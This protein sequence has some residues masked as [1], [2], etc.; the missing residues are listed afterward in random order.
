[1]EFKVAKTTAPKGKPDW[2]NLG[3]GSYYTDHMLIIDHT[4][5]KGWHDGRIIP[6][7][8]LCLD[9]AAMVLHYALE[10]FEGLKAYFT[11]NGEILVFRPDANGKRLNSSARR[12]CMPE[13]PVEIFVEAIHKIV[14]VDKDWVPKLSGSSLYIRP[15]MIADEAHIGVRRSNHH[16]FIIIL[17]PVGAYYP[18]GLNPIKIYVEEEYVR[19]VSGGT[20]VTKCGGNY[21]ASIIAQYKAKD[22]G[23]TQVLWLDGVERKYIEEVGTMNV[24]FRIDDKI[25]T[26]AL[27]GSILAGI[28]RDSVIQLLQKM[29]ITVEERQISAEEII[30]AAENGRL[31]EAF[32]TGT[33]AVISPIGELFVGGKKQII[34]N[35]QIGPLSQKLY[36]T[37]TGIQWGTVKDE[38]GW[39]VPVK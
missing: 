23:Y 6:Y 29:G 18:E 17:S 19:A 39:T 21:A 3:F 26:P 7:A 35:N 27:N 1:M 37:L 33:A 32:G 14:S 12:L 15:F 24:M 10:I 4:E 31:Q 11:A 22:Q 5:E 38:F 9:P 20:G 25:I 16:Q 28:T 30:T 36:D 2:N 34:N 8:P 13:L